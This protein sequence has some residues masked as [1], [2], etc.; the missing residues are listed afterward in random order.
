MKKNEKIPPEEQK[1]Y[2]LL[3]NTNKNYEKLFGWKPG[4]ILKR[5][6]IWYGSNGCGRDLKQA[7]FVR[8]DDNSTWG[9]IVWNDHV[10]EIT[11]QLELEI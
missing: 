3:E 2:I 7:Y 5:I 10:K 4:T 1:Q 6:S 11:D 8:A 9:H